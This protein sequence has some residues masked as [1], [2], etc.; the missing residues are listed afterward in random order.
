MSGHVD[1]YRF[2]EETQSWDRRNV[3]GSLFVV[4]RSEE[5]KY[6]FVVLNHISSGHFVTSVASDFLMHLTVQCLLFCAQ[7]T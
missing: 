5:P 7:T 1:L 4:S 6:Q 2:S 3:A